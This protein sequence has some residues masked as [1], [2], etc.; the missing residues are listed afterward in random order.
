M[1]LIL[2][3]E[4]NIFNPICPS[5]SCGRLG[6]IGFPFLNRTNPECGLCLVDDC[7]EPNPKIQLGRDGPW[8]NIRGISQNNTVMLQDQHH[9]PFVSFEIQSSPL[10]LKCPR[11]VSLSRNATWY[12]NDSII[13]L[14]YRGENLSRFQPQC[15][16]FLNFFASMFTLQ[17][18]V[19]RECYE[20]HWGGSQCRSD[21]KFSA[22]CLDSIPV[23]QKDMTI[24][25]SGIGVLIIILVFCFREKLLSINFMVFWKKKTKNYLN[26]EVFL[27]NYRSLTPKRYSY[28]GG[29]GGVYKG[30]L[31]DGRNVA[32]KVLN[33]SK[34]NGEEFINEV[35]SISRTFHVNIVSLYGFCFEGRRRALIYEFQLK[36]EK[37][38]KIALGIARGLEYLHRGCDTQILHFDIKPH[39]ILLDENFCPKISD[40]GLAKICPKRE[41]II[42]MNGARGTVGYIALEVFSKHFGEVSHKSDVYSYRMMVLEMARGRK[43]LDVGRLE[44]DEEL[45]LQGIENEEDNECERKML[46]VSLWCIQTNPSSR[47]AM[48][49]VVEMLEGRLDSL[50]FPPKPFLSSPK[51]E[52]ADSLPSLV[53]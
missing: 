16:E 38:Y 14:S 48:N 39:N 46:V 5:F 52:A 37:L 6:H 12:C 33:D 44:V 22:S 26:I 1:M 7:D 30:K 45:G 41:S 31:L 20:C 24:A 8:F 43:N 28:S 18:N 13:R 50:Q 9:S 23:F 21:S 53:C 32:V 29:Y 34:G 2:F 25:A 36:W 11:N 27:R 40:F 4:D 35:V 3:L 49:R 17:V 15:V 51:S 47:P 19:T 42:S 10:L